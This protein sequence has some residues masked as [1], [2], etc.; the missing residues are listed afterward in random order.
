MINDIVNLQTDGEINDVVNLKESGNPISIPTA[1]LTAAIS[2]LAVKRLGGLSPEAAKE[3]YG[4]YYDL[5]IQNEEESIQA[6]LINLKYQRMEELGQLTIED[7]A[8][9]G[10]SE[11]VKDVSEFV[12]TYDRE[13]DELGIAEVEAANEIVESGAADSDREIQLNEEV[14]A[15]DDTTTDLP[16]VLYS[17]AVA[18]VT[19]E[20]MMLT[21]VIRKYADRLGLRT[22]PELLQTMIPLYTMNTFSQKIKTED[23]F[24][25]FWQGNDLREQIDKFR[26]LSTEEKAKLIKSLDDF[27][28]AKGG[29]DFAKYPIKDIEEMSQGQGNNLMALTYFSY[30]MDFAGW[31]QGLENVVHGLD[32]TLIGGPVAKATKATVLLANVGRKI[33]AATIQGKIALAGIANG[34]RASA[35]EQALH[36]HNG[37]KTGGVTTDSNAALDAAELTVTKSIN[38]LTEI[39]DTAGISGRV[40]NQLHQQEKIADEIVNTSQVKYLDEIDVQGTLEALSPVVKQVALV[41]DNLD[42]GLPHVDIIRV[43][44]DKATLT[45]GI[46]GINYTIVFGNKDG[47]GFATAEI[48][49]NFAKQLKL[50]GAVVTTIEEQGTHFIKLT[51][52][53][54]EATGFI[55]PYKDIS[56]LKILGGIRGW[57][58]SPTNLVDNSTRLAGHATAGVR[59]NVLRLGSELVKHINKL[60]SAEKVGLSEVLEQGRNLEGWF[61]LHDLKYKFSLTD[62][63][64]LAYNSVK[65]MDD[66]NWKVMNSSEYSRKQRL[67]FKTFQIDAAKAEAIGI[68]TTFDAIPL[69]TIPNAKNKTIYDITSGKYLDISN[70]K[71]LEELQKKGYVFASLEGTRD[72]EKMSAV[73]YI[74]GSSTHMKVKPLSFDQVPYIAGGRIEYTGTH[75]VKQ[76]RIRRTEANVPILLKSRT[77]GVSTKAEATAWAAKMEAGRKI[78]LDALGP[79]GKIVAT[80]DQDKAIQQATGGL[81]SSV[82]DYVEYVG[83]KDLHMPF[84]VVTDNQ[85]LRSVLQEVAK[86]IN[87]HPADLSEANSIQRMM[88]YRR[89]GDHKSKRGKRKYGFDGN[90]APVVNPRQTAINSLSRALEIVTLDKWKARHIDKFYMTF[91]EVLQDSSNRTPASHF[92]DTVFIK[93]PTKEQQVLINQAELMKNHFNAILNTPTVWDQRIKNWFVSPLADVF[94]SVSTKIGKP[95]SHET[96]VNLEKADPIKFARNLAYH[97]HL[98]LFNLKQPV[99][100][101]QATLLMMSAN[102]KNGAK[103]AWLTAPMRLMLMSSNPET[104]GGLARAAGKVIGMSGDDVKDLY[105]ILQKSGTWRMKGGSLVEQEEKLLSSQGIVQRLLDYGTV[106]FLESERMNK[107]AATMSAA[108]DWKAANPGAKITDEAIDTIRSQGELYVANMNRVDRA[109]WQHGIAALPTQFWSYQARALEMMLPEMLGGSKHFTWG[110]K[111]RMQVAQL[112]LYGIG[113][114][115]SPRYGLRIRETLDELYRERYGDE[116]PKAIGDTVESGMIE[117]LIANALDTEVSFANR[118]GLGLTESGWG[119]ILTKIVS[120]DITEL[121]KFDAVGLGVLA[122]VGDG[123]LES[124]ISIVNPRGLGFGS[125]EHARVAWATIDHSLQQAISSYDVY[126][127]A[128]WAVETGKWMNKQGQIT[129]RNVTNLEIAMGVMGLDPGD[130]VTVRAMKQALSGEKGKWKMQVDLLTKHLNYALNSD[131]PDKWDTYM[132]LRQA[133]LGSLSEEDKLE[134][135]K[136]ILRKAKR[137]NKTIMLNYARKYHGNNPLSRED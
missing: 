17:D 128:A 95:L 31:E 86:G 3:K 106:P 117:S 18:D 48:A 102:P 54:D 80:V 74:V 107:I 91:G 120:R 22:I 61:P 59:E 14:N 39:G 73:Q 135:N 89:F 119:Q 30:L 75:F 49:E 64:I 36:V 76:G 116:L 6:E 52:P 103:A 25:D 65:L 133:L 137:N 96:I 34:N 72:A 105:D 20:K 46:D 53:V 125:V 94:N 56:D 2:T 90:P 38:P 21:K 63:Q 15:V 4:L 1:E 118:A 40:V 60:S 68:D 45:E 112:G 126:S 111:L 115:A 42:T 122:K 62:N 78:A 24:N 47:Q 130:A 108:M 9:R 93:N 23:E 7:A 51:R 58:S 127:R 26:S 81:Y 37:V 67:G 11:T 82:D 98:G 131:S 136:Q 85:E 69:S 57:L 124:M 70:M 84:E 55:T 121:M 32:M 129:D 123:F 43:L 87:K 77:H 44:D 41:T 110:Q 113:G 13:K 35:V 109:A 79:T 100:Q 97:A 29:F 83:T 16:S 66:I 71:E 104:L 5:A 101:L 99:V 8:A 88:S 132:N 27:F 50:E 114:A 28:D 10:D 33:A 19:A 134:I 92:F 12:Y